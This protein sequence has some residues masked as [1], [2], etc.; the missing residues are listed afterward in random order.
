MTTLTQLICSDCN[1]PLNPKVCGGEYFD[2][3]LLGAAEQECVCTKCGTKLPG[4][5]NDK[6]P[7]VIE[8]CAHCGAPLYK[9]I[10]RVPDQSFL[11]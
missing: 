2:L 6:L 8:V 4:C 1:N 9:T 5:Q 11:L 7:C 3:T 10:A